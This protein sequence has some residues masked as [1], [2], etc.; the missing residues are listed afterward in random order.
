MFCV[1]CH[2]GAWF[3]IFHLH[4][5]FQLFP[6]T[7]RD[8]L[9]LA[10]APWAS[11]R[12]VLPALS[13]SCWCQSLQPCA[14]RPQLLSAA[15]MWRYPCMCWLEIWGNLFCEGESSNICLYCRDL[16]LSSQEAVVRSWFVLAGFRHYFLCKFLVPFW[17]LER[18]S[19]WVLDNSAPLGEPFSHPIAALSFLP[20]SKSFRNQMGAAKIADVSAECAVISHSTDADQALCIALSSTTECPLAFL[21]AWSL[22]PQNS[23]GWGLQG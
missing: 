11:S 21:A 15:L 9:L 12:A 14:L 20:G 19:G 7:K 23:P 18:G 16:S 6:T 13:S 17:L 2:L 22:A 4:T 1:L 5:G 10:A 3:H 8:P